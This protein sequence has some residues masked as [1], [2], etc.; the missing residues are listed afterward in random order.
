MTASDKEAADTSGDVSEP[1]EHEV[2]L[3]EIDSPTMSDRE[4]M[5]VDPAPIPSS[6]SQRGSGRVEREEKTE[7]A[8]P[9]SPARSDVS[10]DFGGSPHGSVDMNDNANVTVRDGRNKK[11]S[12]KKDEKAKEKA[13]RRESFGG[14][15]FDESMASPFS[16]ND[17]SMTPLS[18]GL[19]PMLPALRCV[20][21]SRTRLTRCYHYF[22]CSE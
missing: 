3:P 22:C 17:G 21:A 4:S 6:R 14:Q 5:D 8:A 11:A 20:R 19:L 16:M 15:G 13:R 18:N 2:E 7:D 9:P 10:F 12:S 1:S